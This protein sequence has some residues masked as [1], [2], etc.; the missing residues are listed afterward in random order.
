[1]VTGVGA[2]PPDSGR[3]L[4]GV[5]TLTVAETVLS[6]SVDTMLPLRA[7]PNVMASGRT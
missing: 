3:G 6:E 4:G 1:M 7:R 2:V 5:D